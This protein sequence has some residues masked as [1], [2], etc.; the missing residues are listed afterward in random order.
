MDEHPQVLI[1]HPVGPDTAVELREKLVEAGVVP[2]SAVT[3]A[4]T[5]DESMA[6][7]PNV[8]VVLTFRFDDDLLAAADELA[9]IQAMSAGVDHF[10]LDRL[11]ERD[12]VLTSAS[13]V[14][15]EP[16]A[17]QVLGYLLAFERNLHRAVRQQQRGVW[18]RFRGG[19]L[20]DKTL[21]VIGVGAI[22]TR[23]AELA[24]AVGMDVIGTKRDITDVPDPVDEIYPADRHFDVLLDADHVVIACPLTD[25][26]AG[27]IGAD[28]L[29]AMDA[30]GV[31]VNVSRGEV[32]QEDALVRTLQQDGIGGAALDVFESEPLPETSPLWNLSN[33]LVTPHMAGSTP[34][35]L[36]RCVELF[37]RNYERFCTGDR[38]GMENRIR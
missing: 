20:R 24:H 11:A 6:S 21:G 4:R 8:P 30:E 19:E 35:Y 37:G 3:V 13:G 26:T 34:H 16:I 7:V 28:E 31:L 22:G 2:E 10:D 17:E 18:E 38:S 12:V 14:H 33:V 25:D 5:P 9:W 15:A 29:R 27:L 32:V 23:V 36:D 1:P